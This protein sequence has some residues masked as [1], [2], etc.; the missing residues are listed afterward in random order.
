MKLVM[1]FVWRHIIYGDERKWLEV[2]KTK[3]RGYSVLLMML[4][5]ARCI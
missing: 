4:W 5:L 2:G 1:N 3:V